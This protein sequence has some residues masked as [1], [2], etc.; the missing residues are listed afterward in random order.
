VLKI[1]IAGGLYQFIIEKYRD[2]Y[3]R[4]EVNGAGRKRKWISK[5]S[6]EDISTD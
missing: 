3:K 5:K 2:Q 6:Y 1:G 4:E